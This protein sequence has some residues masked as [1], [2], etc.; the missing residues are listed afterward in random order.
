MTTSNSQVT[1]MTNKKLVEQLKQELDVVLAQLN[2]I[3]SK[4]V[5]IQ[6]TLPLTD[7]VLDIL[8]DMIERLDEIVELMQDIHWLLNRTELHRRE[9]RLQ[10]Q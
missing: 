3:Q 1:E 10:N 4:L 7:Y 5:N 8:I 2:A 9:R 6:D